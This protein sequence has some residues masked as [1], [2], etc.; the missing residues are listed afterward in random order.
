MDFHKRISFFPLKILFLVA[1]LAVSF[2]VRSDLYR[3]FQDQHE[4]L[5]ASGEPSFIDPDGYFYLENAKD[6]IR[7]SYSAADNQRA[8]PTPP[9][10][11]E[12]PSLL[13]YSLAFLAETT[14]ISLTWIG[15]YLPV[16][17]GLFLALPVYLYA[18]CLGGGF[19]AA[20][21]AL[22]TALLSHY[23][24]SKTALGRLDTDC[25]NIFFSLCISFCFMR[26]GTESTRK[27]YFY[28]TCGLILTL[29]FYLWWDMSPSA[30]SALSLTPLFLALTFHYRPQ[31]RER[32]ACIGLAFILIAAV[33]QIKDVDLVFSTVEQAIGQLRYITKQQTDLFPNIGLSIEEQGSLSFRE[34]SDYI[35]HG[36]P[37][38][39]A[40]LIGTILLI[41]YEKRRA[42][43]LLPLMAIGSLGLF[44]AERFLS[45]LVPVLAIG[46]GYLFFILHSKSN[47]S[48]AVNAIYI[49]ILIFLIHSS[50]F[51]L[52]APHTF[53]S[54]Q[55]ISG[56]QKLSA[57]TP[58]D[59]VIW[60]WWDIGHPLV[61]WSDR[62]TVS[63]GWIHGGS[64]TLFNALPLTMNNEKLA[65][66]FINFYL[67]HGD[68]G[69]NNFIHSMQLDFDRGLEVIKIVLSGG[70]EN[71]TDNIKDI[72]QPGLN[73][74]S[75]SNISALNYFFPIDNP[76]TF[77][78][79]DSRTIKIQRW[80]QWYSGW[81]T[82]D[83]KGLPTLPTF[84]L[85]H[86]PFDPDSLPQRND[87]SFDKR[88]GK[89]SFEQI[90]SQPVQLA[91]VTIRH[92]NNFDILTYDSLRS[93]PI[94]YLFTANIQSTVANHYLFTDTGR[95]AADFFVDSNKIVLR[96]LQASESLMNRLYLNTS[97]DS[98]YF[99]PLAIDSE[100]YKIWAVHPD[101]ATIQP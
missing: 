6:I 29:L 83:R 61:Y 46:F 73:F 78:F 10:R 76:P 26:F 36:L 39:L 31:G 12:I 16:F 77:I 44:F 62:K 40:S 48:S 27:R 67:K 86:I 8:Y 33:L 81:N 56:M 88:T 57:M 70:P 25:L 4:I 55:T 66:N 87:I 23:Y 19:Y 49:A 18:S 82:K 9:H 50:L 15:A 64:L 58:T 99:T 101:Q 30:V 51:T 17:L 24:I 75:E 13:S 91:K 79:L 21:G 45:F 7:G 38:F 5:F 69:I 95:Y 85:D 42:V 35:F 90:F 84:T 14:G 28:L 1:I 60:A 37:F 98:K 96:D 3:S 41:I 54:G 80:I 89:L 65:A 20:A 97:A 59:S 74:I 71:L 32:V 72:P 93:K 22:T 100:D 34:I 53:F 47:K 92:K 2:I 94:Q 52:R 11:A 43:Y 68:N 63:D